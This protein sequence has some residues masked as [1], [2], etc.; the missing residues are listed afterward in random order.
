MQALQTFSCT[1]SPLQ[2]SRKLPFLSALSS[3]LLTHDVIFRGR[4]KLVT[5]ILYLCV[6]ELFKLELLRAK[7]LKIN[8]P[9][10]MYARRDEKKAKK[11]K[12]KSRESYKRNF[13]ILFFFLL[14]I[15]KSRL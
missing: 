5:H 13:E 2:Q 7:I 11:N 1:S 10:G 9:L 12:K 3:L 14:Y 4:S 8:K 6:Q 15:K